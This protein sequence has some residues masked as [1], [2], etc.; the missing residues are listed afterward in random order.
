MV[1]VQD[2]TVEDLQRQRI[3][4]KFL[5]GAFQW[6]RTEVRIV[7][8]RQEQV[9]RRVGK[10]K[11]DLAIGQQ[12]ANIFQPQL[13]DLDQLILSERTEDDDVVHAIQELRPE[14]RVQL[15]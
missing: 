6:T 8:L 11:R 1:P 15:V 4:N 9:F 10:L 7:A 3:L 2:L 14:V 13:D 12:A 5:D